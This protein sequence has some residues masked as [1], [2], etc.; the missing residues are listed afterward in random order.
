M[1][2]L[3]CTAFAVEAIAALGET[4]SKALSR[5]MLFVNRCHNAVASDRDKD[6]RYD[7]GGF[8][9]ETGREGSGKTG[10]AGTDRQGRHRFYSYGSATA[11]GLRSLMACQVQANDPRIQ[12]AVEW[13]R[14]NFE[15]DRNPG[16]LIPPFDAFTFASF[17]YFCFTVAK[18]L[19]RLGIDWRSSDARAI[20]W[21]NRLTASLLAMQK[22]DGS[23]SNADAGV[24]E[25][26]PTIATALATMAIRACWPGRRLQC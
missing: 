17:Y 11:D 22:A 6:V 3:S 7:D 16:P 25:D 8:F 1:R 2:S 9:L 24:R 15:S 23:W 14:T 20:D 19:G 13:L 21:R 26:E 12:A 10:V 18:A 5:A 4:K